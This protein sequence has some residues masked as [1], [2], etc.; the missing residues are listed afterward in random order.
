MSLVTLNKE[1]LVRV[2]HRN[3]RDRCGQLP[4]DV[5]VCRTDPRRGT[6]H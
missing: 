1:L 3:V 4:L 5:R 6:S 2:R